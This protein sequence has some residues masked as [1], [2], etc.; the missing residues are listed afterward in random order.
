MGECHHP[1]DDMSWHR[2]LTGYRDQAGL[3][4]SPRASPLGALGVQGHTSPKGAIGVAPARVSVGT[5]T[6]AAIATTHVGARLPPTLPG[7]MT[8]KYEMEENL[9]NMIAFK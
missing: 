9:I 4:G 2:G 1:G 7:P 8:P 6:L 3:T 5:S